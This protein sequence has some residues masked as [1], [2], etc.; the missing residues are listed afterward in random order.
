[1]RTLVAI[2]SLAVLAAA[3][4]IGGSQ[5]VRGWIMS[6]TNLRWD[7]DHAMV[8][9]DAAPT[10]PGKPVLILPYAQLDAVHVNAS[11]G[12]HAAVWMNRG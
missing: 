12:T 10:D 8:D 11:V 9:I 2:L 7:S 4:K 3:E 6:V 1:L 5:A